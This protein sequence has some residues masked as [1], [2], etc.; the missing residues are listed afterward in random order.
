V[1]PEMLYIMRNRAR[2]APVG[3]D[4]TATIAGL[5]DE[6]ARIRPRATMIVTAE[7]EI[8]WADFTSLSHRLANLL[9]AHGVGRGEAVALN[10]QNSILYLACV[11]GVTRIGAVGGLINTN[12]PG[13]QLVHCVRE[14]GANVSLVDGPALA[15]IQASEANFLAA[16]PG[17][18]KVVAFGAGALD[19]KSW[20][21]NGDA[22]LASASDQAPQV[23]PPV[24][25]RE[26]ALYIFT[27]G[28]TGL[29]K[30][31]IITHQKFVHGARAHA[32]YS[33]HAKPSD[34][35]Y[36]CLPLYHGT[37]LM[38][39]VAACLVSGASMF[40][41]PKFS[42]S[43]L[44]QE[45]NRYRCTAL[46]YV[47][48]ICRYLLNTPELPTDRACS[49]ERAA[50]NGLRPD[51]WKKFRRRF[52]LKR[53]GE[54]YGASEANGGFMN[55]F[56]KDDTIGITGANIRLVKYAVDSASLQRDASGFA[57]L[58]AAGD[59][60]LMLIEV[61]ETSKFDGYKD[62]G[63]SEKKLERNVFAEGDCWFNSG[64]VLRQVDVGFA[65]NMPHYQ[66]ID[67]LG[68][69]YRW[70]SEN[71]STNEVADILCGF[72]DVLA[73]CVYG[74]NV[75]GADGK[76]GMAALTLRTP[77]EDFDSAGFTAFVS[78]NLPSYARPLFVRIKRDLDMT[79]TYKFTKTT[80]VE[81]GFDIDR[82]A[83]PMFCWRPRAGQYQTL[84]R[85]RYDEIT[86]GRSGY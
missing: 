15:A 23:S 5:V 77:A 40:I 22:L 59:P 20:L 12:L 78:E 38:V 31:A 45:A 57:S 64:D 9:L 46:V 8:T 21:A 86:A 52:G 50:G 51:I 26:R 13:P 1:A 83:D 72:R 82:I 65:F 14:I 62:A 2:A 24:R 39:G 7:G 36:N 54:F 53:I 81:D 17:Q 29:P 84:D 56:N 25:A 33:F 16:S 43:S 61:T 67:R 69:T 49:I 28:T 60:G 63:A 27:S 75:P 85:A 10:M 19:D 70:K 11:V 34:R 3:P 42:A 41:R 37:G 4:D 32:I 30:P 55:V 35:I 71:V 18:A 66:F 47:G 44:V 58:V 74:V 79:G 68:D 73:A 48:E 76:A 6:Q 80:L